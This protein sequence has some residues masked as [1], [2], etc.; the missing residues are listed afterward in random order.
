MVALS[1]LFVVRKAPLHKEVEPLLKF[2]MGCE[3]KKLVALG[4]VRVG[5]GD[6]SER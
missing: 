4:Q 6:I 2:S 1:V 5:D 3:V